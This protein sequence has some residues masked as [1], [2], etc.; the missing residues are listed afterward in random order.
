MT[1]AE[2]REQRRKNARKM[3]VSGRSVLTIR[4]VQVKRAEAL[5]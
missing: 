1:K 3:K 5:K 4:D 2:R